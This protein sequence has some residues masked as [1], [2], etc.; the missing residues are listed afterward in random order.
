[1]PSQ[2]DVDVVVVGDNIFI[3][4]GG[5][6]GIDLSTLLSHVN[7]GELEWRAKDLNALAAIVDRG[8]PSISR[9]NGYDRSYVG[10]DKIPRGLHYEDLYI[11]DGRRGDYRLYKVRM[12]DYAKETLFITTPEYMREAF[13]NPRFEYPIPAP[14]VPRDGVYLMSAP[15][16]YDEARTK[17]VRNDMK[18]GD[19]DEIRPGQFVARVCNRKHGRWGRR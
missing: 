5:G 2:K 4:W 18:Y 1:M 12:G 3:R 7:A 14:R 16:T 6:T 15:Y 8:I 19:I 9:Q 11:I 17:G 10:V 13:C